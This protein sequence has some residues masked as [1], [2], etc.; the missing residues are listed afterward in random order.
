MS[1]T[2]LSTCTPCASSLPLSV[3]TTR[4]QTKRVISEGFIERPPVALFVRSS[5]H[6]FS[7]K[8][9]C[10]DQSMAHETQTRLSAIRGWRLHTDT[11][12]EAL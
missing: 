7:I 8:A 4:A 5:F 1:T 11:T 9:V 3:S 2:G 6:S 12:P 10:T